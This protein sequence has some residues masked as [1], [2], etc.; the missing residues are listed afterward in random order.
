[1]C[2]IRGLIFGTR[3][4]RKKRRS[5]RSYYKSK[6]DFWD[7]CVNFA[8]TC[9][10]FLNFVGKCLCI[11]G[12]RSCNWKSVKSE[13]LREILDYHLLMILRVKMKRRMEKVVSTHTH[14]HSY[15]WNFVVSYDF[16]CRRFDMLITYEV[17]YLNKVDFI[18]CTN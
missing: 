12:K 6:Y 10:L 3:L 13:R 8:V 1:M 16:D 18:D 15:L 14:T 5:F 7:F 2:L 17:L 9:A 11:V 4:K